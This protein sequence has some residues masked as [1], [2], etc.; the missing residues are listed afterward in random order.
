MINLDEF[1]ENDRFASHNGIEI[2]DHGKGYATA[3]V[4]IAPEHLNSA[5]IVHGALVFALADA[6]FSAA[7]NSHGQLALAI[8][9][10]ISFFKASK[11]GVLVA[12]AREVAINPKLAT[13]SIPVTNE[14][15]EAVA[16][17]Q[18]TVYRKREWIDG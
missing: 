17:F 13:Y 11:E 1:I 2:V 8:N 3:R 16:L 5:R 10:N 9:A 4:V 14:A 15:G 12:E 7:S 6:A 18:G